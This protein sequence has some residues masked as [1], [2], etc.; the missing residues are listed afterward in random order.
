MAGALRPDDAE[1]TGCVAPSWT[2]TLVGNPADL[3]HG[4]RIHFSLNTH[5]G[6]P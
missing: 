5:S 4:R 2:V 3:P 1:I 6:R